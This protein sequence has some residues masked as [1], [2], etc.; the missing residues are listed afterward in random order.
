MKEMSENLQIALKTTTV[1]SLI[2]NYLYS[3]D[4]KIYSPLP[5]TSEKSYIMWFQAQH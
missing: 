4:T 2:T 1:C 3:S 5:K